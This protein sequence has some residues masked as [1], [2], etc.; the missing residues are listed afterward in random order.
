MISS[1]NLS[2]II[3]V[4]IFHFFSSKVLKRLCFDLEQT[5]LKLED[6]Y[7]LNFLGDQF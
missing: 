7:F 3:Y 6:S 2:L 4:F 1:K 5:H